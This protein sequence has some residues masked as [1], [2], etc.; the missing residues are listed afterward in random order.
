M[1]SPYFWEGSVEAFAIGGGGGGRVLKQLVVDHGFDPRVRYGALLDSRLP[2][3]EDL[4][5]FFFW[6]PTSHST[7]G[8]LSASRKKQEE[9]PP[10][11]DLG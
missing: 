6:H 7:A 3:S 5:G 4:R 10:G 8:L 2:G 9:E 11:E 1:G